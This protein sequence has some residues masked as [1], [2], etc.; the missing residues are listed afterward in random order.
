MTETRQLVLLKA[1]VGKEA[2]F[3]PGQEEA[4]QAVLDKKRVLVIQKTGWGKSI[5]YFIATKMFRDQNLGISIVISP[6]LALMNNQMEAAER[7]GLVAETVNTNNVDDWQSIYERIINNEIDILF[8]S[9]ERL[10]NHEFMDNVLNKI[11]TSISMLIIDEAHCI[12]DWG[13]DFRPDYKRIK[14]IISLMPQN[15][16]ILATTATANNRVEEDIKIQLG[17]KMIVQRGELTRETL[18][19]EVLRLDKKEERL[20]WISQNIRKLGKVGIIYCLTKRDCTLVTEWLEYNAI[21]V[22]SHIL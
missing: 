11:T 22:I 8:I 1:V 9:P 16:P 10:S 6:L 15:V 13:H 12:S 7:L 21:N 19:I 2:S 3:K 14:N 18:A 20:A 4:I 5:V 17:Q